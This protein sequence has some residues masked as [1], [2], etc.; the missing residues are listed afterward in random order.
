M[1]LSETRFVKIDG[2]NISASV[3][4]ATEAKIAIKE[5][6]QKKKEFAHIKRG[7]IRQRKD[8]ERL[9]GKGRSKNG[10]STGF[11]HGIRKTVS[12]MAS[13]AGAY[14]TATAKMDLPRIEEE[15]AKTDEI[16]HNLDSVMIQ[17]EGKL[18][19]FS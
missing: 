17:I 13:V 11:F 2:T 7:L 12:R 3:N 18:L 14:G 5:I 10:A 4:S 6:R 15:C 9:A 16:L 8:A 1:Q 19:R